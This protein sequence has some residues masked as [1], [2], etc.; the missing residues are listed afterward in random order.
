[1]VREVTVARQVPGWAEAN[2]IDDDGTIIGAADDAALGRISFVQRP[3]EPAR[4]LRGPAGTT[5]VNAVGIRSGWIAG[6]ENQTSRSVAVRWQP[7]TGAPAQI[8]DGNSGVYSVNSRGS[9]GMQDAIA[10]RHGRIVQLPGLWDSG[11]RGAKVLSDRG[12]AAGF[13]YDGAQV[14]AAVW[15]GC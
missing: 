7:R 13:S 15:T 2:D 1:M 9:V 5:N 12:T 4:A 11:A 8:T 6:W 10:H 3:H 14:R